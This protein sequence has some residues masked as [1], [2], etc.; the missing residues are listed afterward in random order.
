[1]IRLELTDEE[2]ARLRQVLRTY[3]GDLGLEIGVTEQ[4][5]MRED[6]KQTKTMLMD[7]IR[8]LRVP[9]TA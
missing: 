6:L 3:L 7:L 5:E 8:R 2:A 1:M 4:L 9:E